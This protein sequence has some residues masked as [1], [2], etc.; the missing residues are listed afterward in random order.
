MVVGGKVRK[1]YRKEGRTTV[2]AASASAATAGVDTW[3][4]VCM[5]VKSSTV[6]SYTNVVVN[7]T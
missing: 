7:I 5:C 2:A 6:C 1:G 4:G 3:R